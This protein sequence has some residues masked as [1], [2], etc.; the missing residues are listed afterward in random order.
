MTLKE[1]D[2]E[3]GDWQETL[4]SCD[5]L[6]L[7]RRLPLPPWPPVRGEKEYSGDHVC[8]HPSPL[9]DSDDDD[10]DHDHDHGDDDDNDDDNDDN[11]KDQGVRG[12]SNKMWLPQGNVT[13]QLWRPV[14]GVFSFGELGRRRR[15]WGGVF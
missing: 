15:G 9:L 10:D 3:D 13:F 8:I 7:L 4:S 6:L 1:V 14:R 11:E 12:S 2:E 5:T